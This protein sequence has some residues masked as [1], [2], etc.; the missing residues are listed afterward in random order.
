[1]FSASPKYTLNGM[2]SKNEEM[3]KAKQKIIF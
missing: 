3:Q 1:M 2:G